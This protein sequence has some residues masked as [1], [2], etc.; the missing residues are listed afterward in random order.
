MT[1]IW[2]STVV[3]TP[4]AIDQF[5]IRAEAAGFDGLFYSDS[6][7]LRM[8]LWVALALASKVTSRLKLGSNVTNPVTRHPAVTASAAATLQETSGGRVVLGVGRG[9]SALAY[10][11]YGP[12]S[13]AQFGVFLQRLQAYLRGEAVAFDPADIA[14]LPA[15]TALGYA[16]LPAESAIRWLPASQ[17]KVPVTVVSSGPRVIRLGARLADGVSLAVG[18]DIPRLRAMIEIAHTARKAAGLDPGSLSL[19]AH[20]NVVV[21]PDRDEARRLAA[22]GVAMMAR[23]SVMRNQGEALADEAVR[24]QFL[25]VRSAYDM[26]HHGGETG[27]SHAAA[28]TAETVDRFGIAGPPEYCI[29]RIREVMQLGFDRIVV[30]A[31]LLATEPS[32][33]LGL[34][35]LL[36]E[37]LPALR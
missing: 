35:L 23:W 34:K 2:T 28:V 6:Q 4:D 24:E 13:L 33:V 15:L 21:H 11:G 20:L 17:P 22:G 27:T 29:E 19:T 32:R 31:P 25:T 36:D 30:P 18:A 14:G 16:K 7:N 1:E 12:V 26:T 9:D 37:V 3:Q 10:L 8:E 5:A